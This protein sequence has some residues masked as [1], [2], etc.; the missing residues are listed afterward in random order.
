[1]SVFCVKGKGHLEVY[2][3]LGSDYVRFLS[4]E[5]VTLM[6]M[7]FF[8][9]FCSCCHAFKLIKTHIQDLDYEVPWTHYKSVLYC[10]DQK[11]LLTDIITMGVSHC[12]LAIYIKKYL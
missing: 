4:G 9:G 3:F 1:M 12:G 6:V 10:R 2:V 5:K 7:L 11:L 8:W